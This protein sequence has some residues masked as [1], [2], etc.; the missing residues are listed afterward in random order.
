MC[1]GKEGG[2]VR[3]RVVHLWRRMVR[4]MGG[5]CGLCGRGCEGGVCGGCGGEMRWGGGRV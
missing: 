4:S 5:W 1:G 2:C 3:R